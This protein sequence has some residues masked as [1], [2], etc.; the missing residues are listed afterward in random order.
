MSR[1]TFA[2]ALVSA[3]LATAAPAE[4][5]TILG[6]PDLTSQNIAAMDD[7]GT[8]VQSGAAGPA[9]VAESAGILTSFSVRYVSSADSIFRFKTI[10]DSKVHTT[11][12]VPSPPVAGALGERRT[13]AIRVPVAPGD[14]ISIGSPRARIAIEEHLGSD[15]EWSESDFAPADTVVVNG[16]PYSG[17]R[18]IL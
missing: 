10:R 17:F 6:T 4:A 1:T 13:Y 5:A 14:G 18:M 11:L 12:D 15:V 9:Y 16:S 8:F 7:G 2:L 3:V